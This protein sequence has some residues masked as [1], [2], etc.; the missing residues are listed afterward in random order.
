VAD[1]SNLFAQNPGKMDQAATFRLTLQLAPLEYLEHVEAVAVD[2]T[3]YDQAN[4]YEQSVSFFLRKGDPP[5]TWEFPL[6]D[7]AHRR[8]RMRYRIISSNGTTKESRW[9]ERS[10][11]QE[12]VLVGALIHDQETIDTLRA[13]IAELELTVSDASRESNPSRAADLVHFTVAAPTVLAAAS[14]SE[15]SLWAH[16]NAQRREVL[17]RIRT[18]IHGEPAIK[19]KGPVSL[20]RGSMLTVS[21]HI[22]G[23][24][25]TPA[26]DELLWAGDIATTTFLVIVPEATPAGVRPGSIIV[27]TNGLQIARVHFTVTVGA[28]TDGRVPLPSHEKLYRRAFASYAGSDRDEVLRSIQGMQKVAPQL[29]VFLDVLALRSGEDWERRLLTVIP[30]NDVFYLFWSSHARQSEWVEREWRCAL[31][32]RGLD[33]IDPVPLEPPEAAPPPP[34]LAASHFNDWT[35]AFRRRNP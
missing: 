22:D 23:F 19:S 20:A 1:Q 21:A 25:V 27:R 24:E 33:F 2:L 18:A 35:L 3:Y 30:M 16:T 32:S 14:V 7:P 5:V 15:L 9:E 28:S 10:L 13:L 4:D 11:D 6:R 29:H 31:N 34:E 26:A 17:D 12:T 8:Y